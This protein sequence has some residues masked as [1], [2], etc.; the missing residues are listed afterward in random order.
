MKKSSVLKMLI[1]LL[2]IASTLTG[3]GKDKSKEDDSNVLNLFNW[4]EYLPQE[5]ID[6]FEEETGIVVNYNTYSSNEEMLAKIM[7]APG[8]YDLAVSTDY[9]VDIMI[10]QNLLEEIDLDAV[11]GEE[12]MGESYMNL[13]FDPENKYSLPYMAG[14]A[15]IAVNTKKIDFEIESYEDLWDSRLKDNIVVLD[16]QRAVMGVALKKLGRSINE[17][18]PAVLDQAAKELATLK[19]NIKVF[20]SDSPKSLLISG[21]VAVGYVWNGEAALAQQEN[22]D[23]KIVMPKEGLYLW[24][25][26]FVI[27]KGAPHKENAELFMSFMMRPENSKICADNFPYTNPNT[28]AV[29]LLDESIKSNKG[30]YP[31]KEVYEQGEFLK[32]VGE[33]TVIYDKIWTDFKQQ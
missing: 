14:S 22:P 15:L 30:V 24:Q 8:T 4:S 5:L 9:M 25:D 2:V 28:K 18:D 26:N 10:K 27:P 32:D 17:T 20:D 16:D 1:I 29:E 19:P 33:T 7:T 6:Q 3:C 31:D 12:N 21:E 13:S 23:I 11:E